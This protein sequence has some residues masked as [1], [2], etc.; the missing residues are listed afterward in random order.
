MPIISVG[1]RAPSFLVRTL[2][3]WDYFVPPP[4]HTLLPRQTGGLT[5]ISVGPS[6]L[7]L[8]Q[9]PTIFPNMAKKPEVKGFCSLENTTHD[10]DSITL[11]T[12]QR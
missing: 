4:F 2:V 9:I 8:Y 3:A 7:W 11:Y 6:L 10:I 5:L 1:V 12:M